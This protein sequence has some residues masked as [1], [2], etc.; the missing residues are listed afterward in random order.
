MGMSTLHI[1]VPFAHRHAVNNLLDE[2]QSSSSYPTLSID[3]NEEGFDVRAEWSD[4]ETTRGVME[5]AGARI[6]AGRRVA[7]FD[8]KPRLSREQGFSTLQVTVSDEMREKVEGVLA[9][10]NADA[11]APCLSISETDGG[12]EVR[13]ELPDLAVVRSALRQIGGRVSPSRSRVDF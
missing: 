13:A 3:E 12:F 8:G 5:R 1:V 6:V 10:V 4:L 2:V 11:P 9:E 7:L